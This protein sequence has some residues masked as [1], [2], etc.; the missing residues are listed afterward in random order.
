MRPGHEAATDLHAPAPNV[1]VGLGRAK[2]G[3]AACFLEY[4]LAPNPH[5]GET[6]RLKLPEGI[7]AAMTGYLIYFTCGTTERRFSF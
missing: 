4:F 3:N 6:A 1:L 2:I 5:T 7:R